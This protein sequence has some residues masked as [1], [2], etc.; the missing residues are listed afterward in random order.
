MDRLGRPLP[1]ESEEDLLAQQEAFLRSG[2][3]PGAA[4]VGEW[5]R[6]SV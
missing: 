5:D 3:K 6:E 2:A 1:G 4:V